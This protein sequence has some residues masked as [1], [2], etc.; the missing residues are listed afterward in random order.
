[1]RAGKLATLALPLLFTCCGSRGDLIIGE[2]EPV[3]SAGTVSVIPNAGSGAEP[4]TAG[5]GQGAT[6]GSGSGGSATDGGATTL[7]GDGG[8][9]EVAGGAPSACSDGEEP[10]AGSLIHRYSFDGTGST[11]TDSVGGANG[12][13]VGGATLDGSGILTLPGNRDG[14]PD[15]YVN[16]PNG[17]ISPLSEVTIVAWTTW[18]GGAGYQ[19]VFDFGV[20]DLG[21]GQGNSGKSYIAVMP[22]TGF[23]NGTG[24]GAE[25]AAPGSATLQLPSPEMMDNRPAQVAFA[26]KSGLS[27]ELFLDGKSLIQSFTSLKLSDIKDV[28]NWVGESQWSKDHAYHGTF[29]ELR[30]YDSAL[31]ACQLHTL[32]DRGP[33]AL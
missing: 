19:R 21:E 28:N 31:T 5:S 23:A 4:A 6:G 2:L 7:G 11:V 25:I 8:T 3:S 20:S 14:Q 12:N 30:I 27:L 18:I 16:L 1:M 9:P 22:S 13:L 26:F 17:L 15:Q 24:L 33:D 10:P 32:F 29:D